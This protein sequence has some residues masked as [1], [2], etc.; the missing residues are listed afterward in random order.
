MRWNFDTNMT[1]NFLQQG[2]ITLNNSV[3]IS[4]YKQREQLARHHSS[5]GGEGTVIYKNGTDQQTAIIHQGDLLFAYKPTTR[6]SRHAAQGLPVFSS[7]NGIM[8]NPNDEEP[9]DQQ[10]MI[11]G[12]AKGTVNPF[13]PAQPNEGVATYFRGT[14]DVRYNCPS[15]SHC[16]PGT[17]LMFKV[18]DIKGGEFT[19]YF[20]D[21][22][23]AKID[24]QVEPF[25][26]DGIKFETDRISRAAVF[27]TKTPLISSI[28]VKTRLTKNTKAVAEIKKAATLTAA[29]RTLEVLVRRG[30]VE[31]VTPEARQKKKLLEEFLDNPNPDAVKFKEAYEKVPSTSVL[32]ETNLRFDADATTDI[33]ETP[34]TEIKDQPTSLDTERQ[35][36]SILWMCRVLGVSRSS[37]PSVPL[38]SGESDVGVHPE[39]QKDVFYSNLWPHVGG[40]EVFNTQNV[41]RYEIYKPLSE[42]ITTITTT[43]K[44]RA[45]KE[46]VG[47]FL[48]LAQDLPFLS[49]QFSAEVRRAQMSKVIGVALS[50]GDPTSVN[51][52]VSTLLGRPFC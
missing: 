12:I 46:S 32:D 45:A 33:L 4:R 23:R 16:S 43:V 30:L 49:E 10:I 13:S 15:G 50:Y 37:S 40:N 51:P 2:A 17:L 28:D 14:S 5:K 6:N 19:P 29:C 48:R 20:T 11:M 44:T 25:S 27:D 7:L 24:L 39:V 31:I 35:L 8:V 41:S 22:P 47:Q 21:K 9:L 42:F 18:P 26:W 3:D 36:N 1:H 34:Y 52:K 38:T